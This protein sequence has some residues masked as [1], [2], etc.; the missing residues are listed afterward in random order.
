MKNAGIAIGAFERGLLTPAPF[1][2]FMQGD[3]SALTAQQQRGLQAFVAAGCITCHNGPAVGGAMYQKLGLVN[4]YETEDPGRFQVT[5]QETDRSVF[6]VPSLRNVAET[7]PWF[8]DGSITSLDEAVRLMAW[9]Q[10]GRRPDAAEVRDIVAFLGALTG[11]V[12]PHY[13]AAPEL[14]EG[15][16]AT[17]A[18]DP[19]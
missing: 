16:D 18:P 19:S 5:G 3:A 10:L 6:K 15:T 12:D 13:V 7:G 17:P 8:H 2:R 14:P 4:A 11:T 1:D 9:H